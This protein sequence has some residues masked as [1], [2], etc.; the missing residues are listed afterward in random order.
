MNIQALHELGAGFYV[1]QPFT[2]HNY[3][4]K[5]IHEV[6]TVLGGH[7]QVCDLTRA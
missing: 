6:T 7:Q 2:L 5:I 4:M 1:L 3:L